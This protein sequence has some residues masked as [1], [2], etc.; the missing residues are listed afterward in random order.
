MEY[1]KGSEWGRWDLH[2][3]TPETK[4]NDRFSGSTSEEKWEKFYNAIND[5]V[6]DGTDI[7]KSI[8]AIGITDYVCIE[9]YKKVIADKRLPQS[10]KLILP[11]VEMRCQPIANDSPINIH[12]IFPTPAYFPE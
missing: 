11:N 3:H 5:Y 8:I 10:I 4:K 2:I 9:N 6:S 12:F 7:Q 1:K